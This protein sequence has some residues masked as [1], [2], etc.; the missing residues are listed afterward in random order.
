MTGT[1]HTIERVE[2]FE[3]GRLTVRTLVLDGD[4][5]FVLAD[6]CK[7]LEIA[8]PSNVA[9]RLDDGLRRTHTLRPAEGNRGNPN[10][11]IVSEPGMYEVVLR[12]DKPEAAAFRRWI[13]GE[14]LPTI[15]KTGAYG[16]A[17]VERLT[18]L[19][20]ARKLV[21]AEERA[22]EGAK[23]K[24]AI[25]AGNGLTLREFHK[26]YFSVITESDFMAHLYERGYLINQLGKG[27][28]RTG[29]T[30]AGTRRNGAQHRHPTYK[31]KHFFYLHTAQDQDG[32]RRENTRV[33]P[34][35]WELQL[36]DQLATEGL[37]ANENSAGLFVISGG[38]AKGLGA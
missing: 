17:Q 7:V 16:T 38:A 11:T 31:G 28:L 5:W 30:K 18:P 35:E 19:E 29:G 27:A 37:T 22:E 32:R 20:Y 9:A 26:K 6:L 13:T 36:R 33:R 12:S 3:Y 24:R 21:D 15:R 2:A 10:V 8:N 23:F 34:G 14:V 25:E 4:P 1:Q